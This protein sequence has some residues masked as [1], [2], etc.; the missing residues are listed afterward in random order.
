MK[1]WPFVLVVL[2]ALGGFLVGVYVVARWLRQR[3]TAREV[4]RIDGLIRPPVLKFAKHDDNLRL[5]TEQRRKAADGLRTRAAH[6]DSGS[7]VSD[8]LRRVK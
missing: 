2:L 3:A 5:R 6:V 8:L 1:T 7:S 4:A